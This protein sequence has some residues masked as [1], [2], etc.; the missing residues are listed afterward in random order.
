MPL[1]L[2]AWQQAT[3]EFG[4]SFPEELFW[5]WGG[6]PLPRTVEMLNQQLGYTLPVEATV[7]R[8][9]R[10]YLDM[11]HRLQPVDEVVAIVEAFAGRIPMAIVSGSPRASIGSTLGVLGL[12][13]RFPLI[14]GA[15]DYAHGKPSPE[16]FLTAA[17]R[18]GVD[19][20]R[21]LVFEDAEAG[22][23]SARAAGMDWV[24]VRPVAAAT[25]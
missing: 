11:L 17:H 8:K 4:G 13:S 5:S 24:W 22:L 19:P 20:A 18:L 16:P 23:Q 10:L 1:H 6:I 7:E 3:R 14:V 25:P 21:C 12:A 15:E 9:E 2:E